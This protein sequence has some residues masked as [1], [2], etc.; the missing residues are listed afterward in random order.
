MPN[1][2]QDGA[3]F[4]AKPNIYCSEW[5]HWNSFQFPSRASIFTQKSECAKL[6]EIEAESYS[7]GASLNMLNPPQ[8]KQKKTKQVQFV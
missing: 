7:L 1:W 6:R 2:S 4:T 8:H 3:N 5:K